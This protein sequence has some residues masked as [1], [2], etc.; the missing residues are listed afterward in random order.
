LEEAGLSNLEILRGATSEVA[1]VFGLRD[2]GVVEVGKRADL[3][4]LGG[5]P[6][7]NIRETRNVRRA[8]CGGVEAKVVRH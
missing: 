3:V 1:R 7:G 6:L 4:L 2:R 8:W 5:D